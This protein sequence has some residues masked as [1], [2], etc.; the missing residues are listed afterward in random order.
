MKK[1][2]L[3]VNILLSWSDMS[4]EKMRFEIEAFPGQVCYQSALSL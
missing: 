3:L 2:V 4:T 1:Y